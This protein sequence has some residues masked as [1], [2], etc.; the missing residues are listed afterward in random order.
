MAKQPNFNRNTQFQRQQPEP[1]Q[2]ERDQYTFRISWLLVPLCILGMW[3]LLSHV[4]PVLEWEAVM[5][6]LNV[7]NR[8]RYTRLAVLCLTLIF[9][10]ATVRI[11]GRKNDQ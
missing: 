9:I 5:D 11:L 2:Q 6:F 1:P 3:Y 4:H 7:H 8:E 10:V